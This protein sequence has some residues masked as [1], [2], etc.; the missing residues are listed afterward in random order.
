MEH[1]ESSMFDCYSRARSSRSRDGPTILSNDR[2]RYEYALQGVVSTRVLPLPELGL[3]YQRASQLPTP[4][5]PCLLERYFGNDHT[6]H[7]LSPLEGLL[8]LRIVQGNLVGN[9]VIFV[10]PFD[11]II[12]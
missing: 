3:I 11:V 2:G 4:A 10:E 8:V 7:Q 6:S 9:L 12:H 5:L 1:G